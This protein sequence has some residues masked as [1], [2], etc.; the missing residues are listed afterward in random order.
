M[1]YIGVDLGGTNIAVGLVDEEGKILLKGSTPTL[2]ERGPEPIIQDMGKLALELLEKGGYTIDD[3]ASIGVGVPLSL[4]H[5]S[6]PTR[7]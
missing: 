1:I 7:H 5:I 3:V 2:L 4:I 6:E